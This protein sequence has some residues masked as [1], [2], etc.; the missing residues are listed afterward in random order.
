MANLPPSALSFSSRP[1]VNYGMVAD[2]RGFIRSCS[3]ALAAQ[4]MHCLV[5]DVVAPPEP[6]LQACRGS[7]LRGAALV[8]AEVA[9]VLGDAAARLPAEESPPPLPTPKPRRPAGCLF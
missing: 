9:R 6:K 3:L 8:A 7:R 2:R 4:G 5:N 1:T